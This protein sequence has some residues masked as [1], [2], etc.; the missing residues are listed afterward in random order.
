MDTKADTKADTTNVNQNK[1][2]DVKILPTKSYPKEVSKRIFLR[3]IPTTAKLPG[4]NLDEAILK[5]GSGFKGSSV[6]RGLNFKEEQRFLPDI[7]GLSKDSPNW[8]H[9]TRNYWAGISKPVP[10]KDGLELEVGLRYNSYEDYEKD[11]NGERDENGTLINVAGTPI[12]IA[13]YILWRYCLVYS[14]VANIPEDI[15]KSPKI[16]FFLFSK[17]KE[18]QDKKSAL[19]SRRKAS[20]LFYQRMGERDWVDHVLRVL[21]AID[22]NPLKKSVQAIGQ[23]GDDEKDILLEQ[24]VDES[25][26]R[27]LSIA[28]DK[29]L[30]LKAFVE[31]CIATGK[32][33]RIPNTDTITMDGLTL[34]N[35]INEVV[36]HLNNPKNVKTLSTLKAQIKITT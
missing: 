12:N 32:L 8:E 10:A 16:E 4:Q 6:L 11:L 23:M 35:S 15:G 18:I 36:E 3:R 24:Y 27:F 17:D 34:G 13:E 9:A 22:K 19:N 1:S 30:E 14:R 20:Q 28:N 21:S 31:I 26:E 7:I 25:P 33:N 2:E 29:H 5:I